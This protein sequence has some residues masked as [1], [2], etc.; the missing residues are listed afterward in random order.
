MNINNIINTVTPIELVPVESMPASVPGKVEA[1]EKASTV[2]SENSGQKITA[3]GEPADDLSSEETKQ[4]T[5][6]LN[7][8]MDDLQTNLGFSIRKGDDHQIIV[9][10]KNQETN[11]L[12][13]QI[14]SEELLTLKEK[15]LELTGLILDQSI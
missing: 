15:M 6:E 7:E 13:K 5:S 8:I 11:E 4:L 10:I 2:D 12:I 3:K 9:E 1:P 14:P